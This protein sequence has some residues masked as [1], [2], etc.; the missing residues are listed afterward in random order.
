M[1]EL[2]VWATEYLEMCQY[3]KKLSSD[4]VKAYKIDI[5]QFVMFAEEN[6]VDYQMLNK[7]I[8]HLNQS[9][10]PRSVKRKIA[11]LRAFFGELEISG[12]FINNPFKR[13]HIRIQT[14]QQLPR[15]I[16]D[17]DT[18]LKIKSSCSAF[19]LNGEHARDWMYS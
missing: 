15:V 18:V 16:L 6:V 12:T 9:F 11:S 8:R 2:S 7:Y 10:A 14:P 5:Q 1:N 17:K 3:E 4:T 13:L 19:R